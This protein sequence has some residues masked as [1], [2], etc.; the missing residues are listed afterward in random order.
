MFGPLPTLHK[1]VLV[2]AALVVCTGI[3]FWLGVMPQASLNLRIGLLA[4]SVAG[5]AA[6]YFLVHDFHERQSRPARARRRA[7]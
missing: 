3:G 2:L 1:V 5:I 6:A 7:H 4:G